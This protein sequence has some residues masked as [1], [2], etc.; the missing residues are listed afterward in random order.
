MLEL[1]VERNGFVKTFQ[2]NQDAKEMNLE[3]HRSMFC[4]QGHP[5]FFHPTTL[6]VWFVFI[7][8]VFQNHSCLPKLDSLSTHQLVHSRQ[9]GIRSNSFCEVFCR[10]EGLLIQLPRSSWHND[11]SLPELVSTC[12]LSPTRQDAYSSAFLI[13]NLSTNKQHFFT[14]I[15]VDSGTTADHSQILKAFGNALRRMHHEH[16]TPT[17]A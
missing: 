14:T 1:R 6:L 10:D 16:N 15:V 17:K 13:V 2:Q 8:A 12:L 11:Q 5:P 9:F 3:S 7:I 4:K